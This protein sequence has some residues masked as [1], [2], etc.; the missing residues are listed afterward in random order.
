M[1]VTKHN[2]SSDI[3]HKGTELY[4]K[5]DF[6]QRGKFP[7]H[8]LHSEGHQDSM[9]F[10]LFFALNRYLVKDTVEVIIL[11]EVA[12]SIDCGHRRDFCDLLKSFQSD[13]QLVIT[14]HDAAW[15]KQL[16]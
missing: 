12:M 5:V 14:T 3:S 9:G 2:F 11:A 10:C 8:A 6:Y 15:A 1:A 16:K 7:P 13:R 4:F